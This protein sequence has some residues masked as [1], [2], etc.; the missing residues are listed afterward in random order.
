[1]SKLCCA[2]L[3]GQSPPIIVGTHQNQIFNVALGVSPDPH[4]INQ[5]EPPCIPGM[6]P[7]ALQT[8]LRKFYSLI[9]EGYCAISEK[10][11]E[12]SELHIGLLR[13]N[14]GLFQLGVVKM[15]QAEFPKTLLVFHRTQDN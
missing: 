9:A 7:R 4:Q 15:A 2:T 10:S 8:P 14:P 13:K 1:M 3:P 6:R 11:G 12:L 5:D